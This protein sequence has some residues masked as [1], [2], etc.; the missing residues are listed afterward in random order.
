MYT[1]THIYIYYA[2]SQRYFP[3]DKFHSKK[4][5]N[6]ISNHLPS[7]HVH[8]T[9]RKQTRQGWTGFCNVSIRKNLP[10]SK[11]ARQKSE[12][13]A[14]EKFFLSS[15]RERTPPPKK[16]RLTWTLVLFFSFLKKTLLV[17]DIYSNM[18]VLIYSYIYIYFFIIEKQPGKLCTYHWFTLLTWPLNVQ[19]C[20]LPKRKNP[21]THTHTFVVLNRVHKNWHVCTGSLID[22]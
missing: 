22:N 21:N 8:A 5:K 9:F 10:L 19:L 1:H 11:P 4:K 13:N 12:Q 20:Y 7:L 17:L 15:E 14:R 6:D 18:Y 2:W 16:K 3:R